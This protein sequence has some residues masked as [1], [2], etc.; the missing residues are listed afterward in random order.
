MCAFFPVLLIALNT[1]NILLQSPGLQMRTWMI[2]GTVENRTRI[3]ETDGKKHIFANINF[4]EERVND[5]FPGGKSLSILS[6]NEMP[7]LQFQILSALEAWVSLE[8]R[9]QA[10]MKVGLALD[11]GIPAWKSSSGRPSSSL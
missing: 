1:F 10:E 9:R 3:N 11:E 8:G 5:Y 6:R 7:F 4:F 2:A